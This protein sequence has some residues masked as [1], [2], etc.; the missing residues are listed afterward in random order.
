M[1]RNRGILTIAL[2]LI[3]ILFLGNVLINGTIRGIGR[4]IGVFNFNIGSTKLTEENQYASK[5]D[6]IKSIKLDVTVDDINIEESN[7][8]E[9]KIIEKSNY[10]L[11]ES[12]KLQINKKGDK[13]EISRNDKNFIIGRN[14]INRKLEIYLPKDYNQSLSL[15]NN[16]GDININSDLKLDKLNISQN[17]GDLELESNIKCNTFDFENSTGDIDVKSIT[18]NGDIEAKVGN[19]ECYLESITGDVSIETATGDI[20]VLVNKDSSFILDSKYS[21]GDLDTN[22][23]LD[24]SQNKEKSLSGS[25]GKNAKHTL[26]LK[27]NVGDMSITIK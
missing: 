26:K 7:D 5:L 11:E 27:T 12:E 23:K 13:L 21:V 15:K 17:V 1:R 16:V 10:K 3:L 18:G 25:Y 4:T 6:N 8:K 19:I 20:D 9:I 24:N 22:I 14:N 2:Y